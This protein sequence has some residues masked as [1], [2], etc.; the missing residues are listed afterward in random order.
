MSRP[1]GITIHPLVA[2]VFLSGLLALQGWML[3]QISQLKEHV[4]T[5]TTKIELHVQSKHLAFK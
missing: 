5:M 1:Q 3:L 2:S 4:A